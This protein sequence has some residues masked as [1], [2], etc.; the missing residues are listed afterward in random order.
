MVKLPKRRKKF[1]T[2]LLT[3]VAIGL[4]VCLVS[5]FNL[6]HGIHLQ[7]SDFLY[8][9]GSGQV[10]EHDKQAVIV[11]IDD[12]SLDQLGRFSS[13]PRAYHAQLINTLAENEARV[14]VFDILFSEPSPD[15]DEL[16]TAMQQ[17]GNVI[18]PL[19][20]ASEPNQSAI[21][22]EAGSLGGVIKPLK[23]FEE[24]ALAVG[25]ANMIPDED[26]IVRRLPLLIP[27]SEPAEPA[28]AL[29]AA[30]E[31]LRRPQIIEAPVEDN[32]FYF[33][34][35][36]IP[37]DNTSSMLINYQSVTAAPT[38]FQTVS[39]ADVLRN[40]VSPDTFRN[41]IVLIGI[42]AIGFGDTFWTPMGRIMSGVELHA[43]A[44]HTILAGNFLKPAPA[45]ITILSIL[46][47][48][49][50]CGLAALRLRVLWATLSTVFLGILYFLIA[51]YFFDRGIMLDML[52]PPLTIAGSFVVVN[53]YNVTSER[54]EKREITRTFGQYVSPSVVEKILLAL[55]EGELKLGGEERQVTVM[56]A[57]VRNFTGIA[58]NMKPQELVR[59]LNHH[60]SVIIKAV[61]K[62]DGM[63]NKFGGDSVMAVW[64]AP[65]GCQGHAISAVKAAV[66]AQQA[67]RELPENGA[68][69]PRMEFGIGINTGNALA[70]N[71]G[72]TDRLEYSVIGDVVNISARLASVA[73]GGEVWI[74]AATFDQV[75]DCISAVPLKPLMLKGKREKIK[76]YE[77]VAIQSQSSG[78]RE[79]AV[80]KIR[81]RQS[82]TN[83]VSC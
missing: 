15:D 76:A 8:R 62:Y 23:P 9:S 58:E 11:A 82:V 39:Y 12:K 25:H 42:T 48:A 67:L 60:L 47:L 10:A 75:T 59:V 31:Y 77:V 4:A 22:E 78:V 43:N 72:S 29:T 2:G 18:L 17:A 71:M 69:L 70:G 19:A 40:D 68:N 53:L 57:D 44:V 41:K 24:S 45:S 3:V 30:A 51:F 73:R 74:G 6:L 33:A 64:N 36:L 5:H 56:F 13:W 20:G 16:L 32:H 65:I 28:L 66:G 61:I 21:T 37:L 38:N 34:G 1:I 27:G 83:H 46:L 79:S 26:G 35:R 63:V 54:L 49:F 80:N 55:E 7:S 50:L 14:I 81:K 52:Y